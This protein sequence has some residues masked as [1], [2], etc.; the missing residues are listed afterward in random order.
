MQ[1]NEI[2][3]QIKSS[4]PVDFK[5]KKQALEKIARVDGQTLERLSVLASSDKA[6]TNF[7]SKWLLIKS[8]FI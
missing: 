3:L 5:A 1:K 6:I 4:D 8:M 7:N 2:T